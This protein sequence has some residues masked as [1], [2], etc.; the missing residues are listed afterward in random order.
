M[1]RAALSAGLSAVSNEHLKIL[2]YCYTIK[3]SNEMKT[4]KSER[5][6][7]F[8]AV[9]LFISL[10][11]AS[12]QTELIP[13][14]EMD[15]IQSSSGGKNVQIEAP[16]TVKA[17]HGRTKT[18]TVSWSTSNGATQYLIYSAESPHSEFV[19]I[20]ETKGEASSIDIQ[21]PAG[22]SAYYT[23]R[24]KNYE[25]TI[26]SF[27]NVVFGS[28]MA[29]PIISNITSNADGSA[30]TVTWWMENCSA[31]TYRD[32][33][34]YIVYCYDE[35]G[36]EVTHAEASGAK[37]SAVLSG[38]TAKT[39]YIYQVEAYVESDQSNPEL[40]DKVDEETARRLIPDAPEKLSAE[41]GTDK[42]AVSIRWTLPQFCDVAVS[43]GVYER[44]P[45]YFTIERKLKN[46]DDSTYEKIVSYLGT[47]KKTSGTSVIQFSCN[48]EDMA[49]INAGGIS[50]Q[51]PPQSDADAERSSNY[52]RYVSHS[53]I[54]YCDS[55]AE[56]GKQYVYR[57]Q[58]YVD[59]VKRTVS[60][61]TAAVTA[62]GFLLSK[63]TFS[64]SAVYNYQKDQD[65]KN[66]NTISSIKVS[67]KT[68]FEPFGQDYSYLLYRHFTP[69]KNDDGT[70]TGVAENKLLVSASSSSTLNTETDVFDFTNP[71]SGFGIGYYQYTLYICAPGES[72][73][74][75]A[76]DSIT[77]GGK[78]TVID[79]A[80]KLPSITMFQIKDG[81]ADHF[82]IKWNY[83]ENC[84][85]KL[86]WKSSDDNFENQ[87]SLELELLSD[88]SSSGYT[89]N[90]GTAEYNHTAQSGEGRIY[91]I[92][93]YMG[94]EVSRTY[95]L[96]EGD[97]TREPEKLY[98]LGTAR[99]KTTD[100]DYSAISVSWEPVVK[101]DGTYTVEAYYEDDASRENELAAGKYTVTEEAG[102][103]SCTIT[104]PDGFNDPVR[105]GLPIIM[106]ITARNADTGATTVARHTVR[107]LGPATV[108]A[109][110]NEEPE[111][112]VISVK[113]NKAEGANGYLI[114]RL[115][116]ADNSCKTVER[117]VTYY[118]TLEGGE[119]V[120]VLGDYEADPN[121]GECM[122]AN[123][124]STPTGETLTL[125]DYYSEPTTAESAYQESQSKLSWGR[126][127]GYIVLPVKDGADFTFNDNSATLSSESAVDYTA[128]ERTLSKTIGSTLGYGL[129]LVA[130]KARL[131]TIQKINWEK[132]NNRED[133]Q[134]AVYRRKYLS[135]GTRN[136]EFDLVN[137]QTKP[138]E[139]TIP[140][141]DDDLYDAFEYVVKYI[142][143]DTA[144]SPNL[145]LPESLFDEI[146]QQTEEPVMTPNGKKTEQKNKGYLLSV[147]FAA[148][149]HPNLYS[150]AKYTYAE[151]ISW[152]PWDYN[153]RAVGPEPMTLDIRN[154]NIDAE[155]HEVLSITVDKTTGKYS[156]ETKTI[157]TDTDIEQASATIFNITSKSLV[158]G[159]GTAS[160]MLKVLRDY[161]HHYTLTLKNG[162]GSVTYEKDAYR[163][164][165]DEELVKATMLIL[166]AIEHD[167]DS[168]SH[169]K[170]GDFSLDG[171]S[172]S[173]SGSGSSGN[174]LT[175]TI[176]DYV[177]N[178]KTIPSNV[179]MPAFITLSDSG[180][181]RGCK[182]GKYFLYLACETGSNFFDV[183][184]DAHFDITKLN[185]LTVTSA[186]YGNA[187]VKFAANAT[188]FSVEVWKNNTLTLKKTVNGLEE[189]RKWF[190][191][192]WKKEYNLV[193]SGDSYG[194]F[195]EDSTY[196]W[197]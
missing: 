191:M 182:N 158:S 58:S 159:K 110:A 143:N 152:T 190:P 86:E 48:E 64:A 12:C 23:V 176:K 183:R 59:D 33:V 104:E 10:L 31:S 84:Q 100:I 117:A 53:V 175:W 97:E 111:S 93:A 101:A 82:N 162:E 44:H 177:H 129:N 112:D 121:A 171:V 133:V 85:Y 174:K 170:G 145:I 98:T 197:W 142:T 102:T 39:R 187:T 40:S 47:E 56:R 155:S 179:Q 134:G 76:Y 35:S 61:E 131:G 151:Q 6:V 193:G 161:R 67:F 83:D 194:Y 147:D 180:G 150:E 95:P 164:I 144:P 7:A 18:V 132:P 60:A 146:A 115:S 43:G 79:D 75:N 14:P 96:S 108:N 49:D 116:Y 160:G 34:K 195:G 69:M 73:V 9:I 46:E 113:W 70:Q 123:I 192:E 169:D 196:G 51:L 181:D 166:A 141:A 21:E 3:E 77:T 41:K 57:V 148:A 36:K 156:V 78:I 27:S 15:K 188:N 4:K 24:A 72:E 54:T 118:C 154:N 63:P 8:S 163:Q 125:R 62:E 29:T 139:A 185:S 52:P 137:V 80:S 149:P 5:T 120:V 81:Y 105:S 167:S 136:N 119:S 50:V 38:L 87:Q 114:R 186:V 45:L 189:C 94:I 130:A 89:V 107:T 165:T 173:F 26:S 172:G 16:L 103:Y 20:A 157:D 135:D 30:S 92:T 168:Q 42:D 140:I 127:Y 106:E 124:E 66:T 126:P 122:R 17:S 37:T 19:Q 138:V 99:P 1:S 88:G 109:C 11:F 2:S 90:G 71:D 178:W 55:T 91:T 13:E 65:G 184:S 153:I 25:G 28:T 128:D 74:T 32:S 22:T 68:T